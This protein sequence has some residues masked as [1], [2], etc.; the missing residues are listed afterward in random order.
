MGGDEAYMRFLFDGEGHLLVYYQS[1]QSPDVG[2]FCRDDGEAA[3]PDLWPG[4]FCVGHYLRTMTGVEGEHT[5]S[6]SVVVSTAFEMLPELAAHGVTYYQQAENLTDED[7]V[8]YEYTRWA[9]SDEGELI[10][11]TLSATGHQQVR[12][13]L[14]G[15]SWDR[16]LY[17]QQTEAGSEFS[18]E[19]LR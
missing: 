8:T 18:C 15:D 14:G 7:T 17:Y 3:D 16:Y 10:D 11:L 12:Y 13:M 9:G 6:G 4:E 1:N 2:W 19:S 5:S